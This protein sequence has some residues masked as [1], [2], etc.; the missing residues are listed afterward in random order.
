MTAGF[1]HELETD[2]EAGIGLE[3]DV[4]DERRVVGLERVGRVVRANPGEE[5]QRLSGEARQRGLE[6]RATDLLTT[7]HVSRRGG[8]DHTALHQFCERVDLGRVVATVGHRDD[9]NRRARVIDAVA[10]RKRRTAA[11]GVQRRLDARI[12][13]RERFGEWP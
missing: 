8:D 6:P 12:T 7:T 5:V 3:A 2:L 10:D 1:R 9:D 11:V 4:T 13:R